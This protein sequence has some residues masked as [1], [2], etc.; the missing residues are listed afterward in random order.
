[1]YDVIIFFYIDRVEPAAAWTVE[2]NTGLL[3]LPTPNAL[4]RESTTPYTT[5]AVSFGRDVYY[6]MFAGGDALFNYHLRLPDF[7]QS[8][9]GL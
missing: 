8:E 4:P 9:S 5:A 2:Y 3:S 7:T 6:K 1:M